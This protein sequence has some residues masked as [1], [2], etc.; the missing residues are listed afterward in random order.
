MGRLV[1]AIISTI[2]E[3]GAIVALVIFG[4]PQL[5]IIFPLAGLI[6]LMVIWLAISIFLFKMGSRALKRK[7]YDILPN[8]VGCKGKVVSTLAPDGM[9]RIKGE[10]WVATSVNERVDL[11]ERVVVIEQD[12]LKLVVHQDVS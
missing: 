10:T 5:G 2:L 11:G 7:P 9:V 1:I 3:E 8:M 12:G 4:L 6:A